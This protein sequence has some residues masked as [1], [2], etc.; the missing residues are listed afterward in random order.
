MRA[1]RR[2][3][4]VPR[5]K[6]RTARRVAP[7]CMRVCLLRPSVLKVVAVVKVAMAACARRAVMVASVDPVVVVVTAGMVE[8]AE[9]RIPSRLR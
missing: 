4:P 8:V 7:R 6:A 1:G 3:R 5:W 2:S 9:A